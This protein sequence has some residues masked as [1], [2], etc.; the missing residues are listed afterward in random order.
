MEK[1]KKEKDFYFPYTILKDEDFAPV[2]VLILK[3]YYR[4]CFLQ[5]LDQVHHIIYI[6]FIFI[7]GKRCHKKI[8]HR[9]L[10]FRSFK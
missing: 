2:D 7:D 8:I 10:L 4:N 6:I 5:L 9:L 1:E 3:D